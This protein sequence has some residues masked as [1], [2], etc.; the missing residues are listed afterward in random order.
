MSQKKSGDGFSPYLKK[1]GLTQEKKKASKD[2]T[3]SPVARKRKHKEDTAPPKSSSPSHRPPKQAKKAT[4]PSPE[5]VPKRSLSPWEEKD[6]STSK[7]QDQ[8]T[9]KKRKSKVEL[10]RERAA[11]WAKNK[12]L[13]KP[14]RPF[15]NV[16]TRI[17]QVQ[18]ERKDK[19]ASQ[20]LGDIISKSSTS[21]TTPEKKDLARE[22][23]GVWTETKNLMKPSEPSVNVETRI[24]RLKSERKEK[25]GSQLLDHIV[26]KSSESAA[27]SGNSPKQETKKV[28]LSGSA[29]RSPLPHEPEASHLLS[30]FLEGKKRPYTKVSEQYSPKVVTPIKIEYEKED[31]A[32]KDKEFSGLA[33]ESSLATN[34]VL[35]NAQTKAVK[36]ES[37]SEKGETEQDNQLDISTAD[38]SAIR[39]PSWTFVLVSTI[40]I[41]AFLAF[42]IV[43]VKERMRTCYYDTGVVNGTTSL[44][45]HSWTHRCRIF[46]PCPKNGI[47][48]NGFLEQCS[49][50]Y[51][52]IHGNCHIPDETQKMVEEAELQLRLETLKH[53]CSRIWSFEPTAL[54]SMP[55]DKVQQICKSANIIEDWKKCR[56]T[57]FPED[58][59]G[60]IGDNNIFYNDS[61][62]ATLRLPT[63]SCSL[64][65]ITR[66]HM[67][68]LL[69]LVA[70]SGVFSYV[71]FIFRKQNKMKKMTEKLVERVFSRLKSCNDEVASSHIRDEI[72][73]ST[74]P[75]RLFCKL[76]P[77]VVKEVEGDSRVRSY[78]KDLFGQR[79]KHWKWVG[80]KA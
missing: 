58:I 9:G 64:Q 16:E 22:Q 74:T 10:A 44:S 48:S 39:F 8:V 3:A 6:S 40:L 50:P 77:V 66:K 56:S 62:A 32:S 33:D 55:I 37:V 53:I 69:G 68:M 79:Q 21:P 61:Y 46:L 45:G 13:A 71:W 73:R 14:N 67:M 36:L 80:P 5:N 49:E 28:G 12:K 72:K 24:R 41:P 60:S 76:W 18:S 75:K 57:I 4:P 27:A 20:L 25:D 35:E 11:K 54:P 43:L 63:I 65:V 78:E 30:A 70:I 7:M 17:D 26:S 19:D 29:T 31:A 38:D 47:C 51:V 23:A 59:F 52:L 2:S 42:L 34:Q 15:E 1:K